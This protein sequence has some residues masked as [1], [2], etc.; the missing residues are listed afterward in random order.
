MYFCIDKNITFLEV[1][2]V[3][4]GKAFLHDID[5]YLVYLFVKNSLI[6]QNFELFLLHQK[7]A[8]NTSYLFNFLAY[9][10]SFWFEQFWLHSFS[11]LK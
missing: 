10:Y 4:F 11:A 6:R 7:Q 3:V 2:K 1:L 8:V 5:D 9:F